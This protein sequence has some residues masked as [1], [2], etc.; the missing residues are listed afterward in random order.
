MDIWLAVL[1]ETLDTEPITLKEP[2]PVEAFLSEEECWRF[3]HSDHMTAAARSKGLME[4]GK[5]Y[6]LKC[7]PAEDVSAYSTS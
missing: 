6:M 1:V 5:F 4:T 3:V 2:V 7:Q